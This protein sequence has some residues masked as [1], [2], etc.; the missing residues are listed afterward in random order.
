MLINYITFE[1]KNHSIWDSTYLARKLR[2]I[3][4]SPTG[5]G[6]EP[7]EGLVPPFL[8]YFKNLRILPASVIEPATSRS[9]VRRC[10]D[11]A[12]PAAS[13]SIWISDLKEASLYRLRRVV[14]QKIVYR[15]CGLIISSQVNKTNIAIFLKCKNFLNATASLK[16]QPFWVAT[17]PYETHTGSPG[18]VGVVRYKKI[19]VQRRRRK[20]CLK[21]EFAFFQSSS[22]F[23]SWSWIPRNHIQVEKEKDNFDIACLRPP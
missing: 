23:F 22:R 11:W 10:T 9:A 8:S 5:D 7:G 3:F 18:S 17:W 19:R 12:N 16:C 6:T 21:S 4:T 1:K 20:S 14:V 2:T 13:F 15:Y